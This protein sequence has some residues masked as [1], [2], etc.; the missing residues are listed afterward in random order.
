MAANKGS[1]SRPLL[2]D[3]PFTMGWRRPR[4][5]VDE[6]G[7][8]RFGEAW[9]RRECHMPQYET[10]VDIEIA[11]TGWGPREFHDIDNKRVHIP[12]GQS[13][14]FKVPDVVFKKSR[15]W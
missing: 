10:A 13:A 2:V 7:H 6:L 14:K 1:T 9:T 11:N 4:A 5:N 12:P 8:D 3:D 15:R